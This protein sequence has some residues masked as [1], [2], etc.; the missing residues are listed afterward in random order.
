MYKLVIGVDVSKEV[1]DVAY[2]LKNDVLYLGQV[3]NSVDGIHSFLDAVKTISNCSN[4][5]DILVCF[6]NTGTYSKLL[7]NTL[8]NEELP[9]VEENPL[10]I[11]AF[12]ALQRGKRD[13]WDA[14]RICEYALANQA[15][16]NLS[17]LTET[18]IEKLKHLF[19]YRAQLV[20]KKR[21]L[22]N[23]VNEKNETL[24][25]IFME[26]IYND[27]QEILDLIKKKIKKIEKRLLEII[28]S[29]RSL[30]NNYELA[31]S[32][33]GV[34]NIIATALIIKTENFTKFSDPRKFASQIG[35][36]P[37]P[38]QS[39][40]TYR[41][42]KSSKKADIEMKAIVSNGVNAAI[43]FDPQINIYYNR[44]K[45]KNKKS[46]IIRNN[47]KNKIIHRVFSVIK[48]GTPYVKLI[49]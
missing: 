34:G 24:D 23:A 39:G 33:I 49:A 7:L 2:S 13:D 17:K 16:L 47:I 28:N 41:P 5:S 37:F 12:C 45:N 26:E 19:R 14:C 22:S 30:K 38:N 6:E 10:H 9:C 11:K 27:N 29:E 32:V 3:E 35:I 25:S 40:K 42:M 36:A 48:R 15:R 46:G 1:L 44:L 4:H 20:D 43:Q 18:S 8:I 21:A 31:S